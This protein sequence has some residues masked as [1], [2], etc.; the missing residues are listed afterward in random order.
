MFT[1]GINPSERVFPR[2]VR[3]VIL[4]HDEIGAPHK[5]CADDDRAICQR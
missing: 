5:G 3:H 1:A 2:G 4:E